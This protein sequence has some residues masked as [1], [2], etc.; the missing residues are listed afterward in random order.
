MFILCFL[1]RLLLQFVIVCKVQTN[2]TGQ[3]CK[4]STGLLLLH[5]HI[6][7]FIALMNFAFTVLILICFKLPQKIYCVFYLYSKVNIKYFMS[8]VDIF[9]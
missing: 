4:Q 6:L 2:K 3:L 7:L 8:H 1:S 5:S 9:K